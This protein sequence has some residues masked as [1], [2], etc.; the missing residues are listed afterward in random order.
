LERGREYSRHP[1]DRQAPWWKKT[2]VYQI[3][4][5]S[6]ADTNGDGIGD[7]GGILSNLDYLDDLGVETIWLSPF[8]ESPQGDFGYDISDFTAV[9]PEYGTMEQ[10]EN[11]IS[12]LHAR[13]KKVVFDMVMNHTSDEHRWFRESRSSKDNPKRDWYIW[14]DGRG[15][16]GGK[17]PNNWLSMIGGS[18]WHRDERT[19]QWYWAS[20]LPFQ[21]DLNYRNPAVKEA[22]FDIVRFWLRKGVDGFRLDIINAVFKDSSFRNNPRSWRPIPGETG[23][24]FFSNPKYTL[25]HPDVFR[26]SKELRGVLDEF[27]DPPRFLVG[28]VFGRMQTLKKYCG[29]R[30]DGLHSVFLF[31]AL[32][33]RFSAASFRKLILE[34]ESMFPEPFSPTWV[35]GNHD[36]KRYIS[37]LG[38]NLDKAKLL[39]A[40]QL[41]V[42]GIPF[43]YY[44]EETGIPQLPIPLKEALDPLAEKYRRLPQVLADLMRRMGD[45]INRDECRTP[46]QWNGTENAGF[47]PAGVQPWLP[48]TRS[49]TRRNVETM[50]KDPGSLL[51]CYR[52]LLGLRE[53]RKSLREGSLRLLPERELPKGVLGYLRE[54]RGESGNEAFETSLVLL[55]FSNRK[56]FAAREGAGLSRL[57]STEPDHDPIEDSGIE[58]LPWEG[59]ILDTSF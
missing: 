52:G 26:F 23:E 31:K 49:F 56:R 8:F 10:C 36:R 2:A 15:S 44:G 22:M 3:Y 1:V 24:G 11:L 6:F 25:N 46:M 50:R 17:P 34:F 41:S 48:V 39:T 29:E 37:K 14:R 43:I 59:L 28:E 7:L 18:G 12:E 32:G 21:P 54:D 13:G 4:P 35:F 20:F 5:R 30:A 16:G 19:G 40:F 33:A 27:S 45:S 42:R 53:S 57:F 58:L 9:A 47:C 55:N 51:N 38:D